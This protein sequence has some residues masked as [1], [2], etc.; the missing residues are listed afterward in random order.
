[1]EK[2]KR[3][4]NR[5]DISKLNP[6][7]VEGDDLTGGYILKFDWYYTG[8]NIG[9]FYSEEGTLYNFHYPKPDQIV[10]QQ[11]NYIAQYMN[12]FESIMSSISYNDPVIGYPSSMDVDS[13]I[14]NGSFIFG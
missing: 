7:E 11:E 13:F 14:D 10:E 8:D 4:N 1:M 6:D 2:I 3:D 5:I 9:G 12:N